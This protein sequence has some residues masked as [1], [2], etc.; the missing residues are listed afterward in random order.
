MYKHFD[1]G[2]VYVPMYRLRSFDDEVLWSPRVREA[3][4]GY[5]CEL[6]LERF[7]SGFG[8]FETCCRAVSMLCELWS[9]EPSDWFGRAV[10]AVVKIC[11]MLSPRDGLQSA[12]PCTYNIACLDG[13]ID[14]PN[15]IAWC[16]VCCLK[17]GSHFDC[18]KMFRHYGAQ[19]LIIAVFQNFF[20]LDISCYNDEQLQNLLLGR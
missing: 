12:L 8:D 17:G 13:S 16:A 5:A 4:R 6:D 10:V 19:C 1:R 11:G 20:R 18:C 2:D 9:E 15:L 14:G 7:D 3:T